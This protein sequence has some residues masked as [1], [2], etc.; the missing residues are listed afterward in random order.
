MRACLAIALLVTAC[1]TTLAN[2][3]PDRMAADE[4]AIVGRIR[5]SYNGAD[6]TSEC[7]VCFRTLNG[8]CYRLDASGLVAMRLPAGTC[9]IR[10]I[11]CNMNGERHFHFKGDAYAF[12]AFP[13]AKT[14]FGD[15]RIDWRNEQGFKPSQFFGLAGAIVDQATNDG[16][17]IVAVTDARDEVMAL[18]HGATQGPDEP[19]V[20]ESLAGSFKGPV[21]L[22]ATEC[23]P[24]RPAV[25]GPGAQVRARPA[26]SG[27]LLTT[28]VGEVPACVGRT[29]RGVGYREVRIT[30]ATE[31][32]VLLTDIDEFK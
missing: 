6:I 22:D 20:R 15:V 7:G 23:A 21:A 3:R 17:A 25:L 8:P 18:Y 28:T 31:G 27:A 13:G 11:A 24:L 14:F 29:D 16:A 4:G 26:A 19:P 30:P 2:Y 5:V 32:Y 10:R 1:D 12:E 9:S